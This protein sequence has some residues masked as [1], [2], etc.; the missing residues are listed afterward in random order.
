MLETGETGEKRKVWIRPLSLQLVIEASRRIRT[1]RFVQPETRLTLTRPNSRHIDASHKETDDWSD[2]LHCQTF[3]FE[4]LW[5]MKSLAATWS[6][7]LLFKGSV[8]FLVNKCSVRLSLSVCRL[9]FTF[10]T[11]QRASTDPH[12]PVIDGEHQCEQKQLR[13]DSFTDVKTWNGHQVAAE[14]LFLLWDVL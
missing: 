5:V 1:D 3:F 13:V 9:S 8:Y 11:L 6:H 14:T 4:D 10:K 2:H 12:N 7:Q